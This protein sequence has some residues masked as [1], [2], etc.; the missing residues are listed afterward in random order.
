MQSKLGRAFRGF[1]LIELLVAIAII[2]IL[3]SLLLPALSRVKESANRAACA[4]NLQAVWNCTFSMGRSMENIRVSG[5][6]L[7]ASLFL[8]VALSAPG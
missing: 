8:P 5:S 1:T 6:R 4:S 3:A 7:P 2:A